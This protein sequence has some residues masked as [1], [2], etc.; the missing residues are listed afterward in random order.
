ML[1][2]DWVADITKR[3]G[4]TQCIPCQARQEK[5]N[6][7]HLNFKQKIKSIL[8]TLSSGSSDSQP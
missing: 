7:F 4:A 6:T 5:M 1:L 8:A 3:I 2:G